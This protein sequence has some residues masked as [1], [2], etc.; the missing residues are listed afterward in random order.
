MLCRWKP[1]SEDGKLILARVGDISRDGEKWVEAGPVVLSGG[2]DAQN[3][4]RTVVF[5]QRQLYLLGTFSS[6]WGYFE[7]PPLGEGILL[8]SSR[9]RPGMRFN[10][11]QCAGCP[12]PQ[13]KHTQQRI[14]QPPISV[15]P[16]SQRWPG[17]FVW[18]DS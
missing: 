9:W 15:G 16:R 2:S 17:G 18:G 12:P 7:L 3:K 4:G 5:N 11:L 14:M 1:G 10:I 8:V 13:K 6:V